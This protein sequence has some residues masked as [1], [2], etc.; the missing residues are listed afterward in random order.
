MTGR[1][2]GPMKLAENRLPRSHAHG[3]RHVSWQPRSAT[4]AA[5][6]ARS[7][8]NAEREGQRTVV[9]DEGLRDLRKPDERKTVPPLDPPHRAGSSAARPRPRGRPIDDAFRDVVQYSATSGTFTDSF[10]RFR[11]HGTPTPS[12]R[13][14]HRGGPAE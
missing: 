3:R 5:S 12:D 7:A 13:D 11:R 8:A 14:P 1:T 9:R 4:A 10:G 2:G 6:D